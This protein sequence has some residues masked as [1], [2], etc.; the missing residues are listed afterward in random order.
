VEKFRLCSYTEKSQRYITLEKDFVIPKEIKGSRFE[1]SFIDMVCRQSEAYFDFFKKLKSYVF[2]KHKDLARDP[3]KHTI[4]E[5]W[6][7]EDA[8]YITPLATQTQVGQTINARNLELALRRFASHPLSEVR[9]LGEAIYKE[10]SEI[11]PSIVIFHQANDFDQ[12]TYPELKQLARQLVGRISPPQS[13]LQEGDVELVEFTPDGDSIVA[14]SL[15]HTST[16]LPYQECKSIIKNLSPEE[17]GRIFKTAGKHLQ[18][19]DSLLREFEYVNLTFNIVLSAACFAQ[20]KRHRM[21]TLT[22]QPYDPQLGV[23]CPESIKEI[24]MEARFREIIDR[25]NQLYY[26]IHKEIPLA[27]P[28]ILTNAHRRRVLLRVNAR[29]LYHISRLRED[30]S[31]QWD[32]RNISQAMSKLASEV[33]P[34][35]FALIGGKDRYPQIYKKIYGRLPKV[36]KAELPGARRIR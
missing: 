27:A 12:K 1:E 2:Q 24:G 26:K 15:L 5:G 6:A 20:L 16:N 8:R 11:A 13:S 14:A 23:I 9:N 31:A 32:I 18:F 10:V 33:M 34:L 22:C 35:T 25:T 3:K 17:L 19:Y 36:T 29:E 28:Y 21:A 7:K 30:A 4:L